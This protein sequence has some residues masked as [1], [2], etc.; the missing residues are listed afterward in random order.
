MGSPM[1]FV[2]AVALV[3]A[4][5]VASA[6]APAFEVVSIKEAPPPGSGPFR[7]GLGPQPG[8]RWEALNQTIVTMMRDAWPG[9]GFDSQIVGGPDWIRSRRFDVNATS[10]GDV[11]RDEMRLMVR[12]ML[13]DRFGLEVR[14]ERR[15]I[16]VYALVVARSDGRLGP[17][18]RKSDLDCDALAAARKRGDVP[19]PTF[20][21][22]TPP[23]QPL[24]RVECGFISQVTPNGAQRMMIS[25]QPLSAVVSSLQAGAGRPVIDR[26]GL[27]DK[28]DI[29]IEFARTGG[30]RSADALDPNAPPSVFTAVQEQ[31]GLKLEARKEAMD[32]LVIED[33][34][35][36]TAD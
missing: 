12:R 29:D 8:G 35:L 23:G 14:I 10:K 25:G 22:P 36:P 17:Q 9:F 27:T 32:V 7:F 31:L 20:P 26:T 18:L 11:P 21:G 28:Y 19:T 3:A 16:E 15:E 6:Q 30:V 5:V 4:R 34:H 2:L 1:R 33:V 24:P 13:A